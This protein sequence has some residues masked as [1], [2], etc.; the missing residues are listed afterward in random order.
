MYPFSYILTFA[1]TVTHTMLLKGL[2]LCFFP[3]QLCK[4]FCVI[5]S[6]F[7]SANFSAQVIP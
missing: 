3:L 1:E 6:K 7:Y 5:L 2:G 4:A